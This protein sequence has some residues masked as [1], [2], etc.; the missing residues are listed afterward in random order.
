M[1]K[2]H[3]SHRKSDEMFPLIEQLRSSGKRREEFCR[4]QGISM[5]VLTYWLRKYR[6]QQGVGESKQG[7]NGFAQIK[8]REPEH[9]S[10]GIEI[11]YP[12]GTRMRCGSGVQSSWLRELLP[13]FARS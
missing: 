12:D 2:S 9:V 3:Q 4:E 10:D 1:S 5:S 7:D 11:I 8:V 6:D 13:T